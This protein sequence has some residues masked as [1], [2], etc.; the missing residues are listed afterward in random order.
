MDVRASILGQ[1]LKSVCKNTDPAAVFRL[2]CS[3]CIIKIAAAGEYLTQS[4]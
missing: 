1:F 4:G 2:Y 3:L